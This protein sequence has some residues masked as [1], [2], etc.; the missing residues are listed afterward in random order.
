MGGWRSIIEG[1]FFET[2]SEVY[3][4]YI[5]GPEKSSFLNADFFFFTELSF[6]TKMPEL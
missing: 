3:N 4:C 6:M 1:P 2:D 5:L